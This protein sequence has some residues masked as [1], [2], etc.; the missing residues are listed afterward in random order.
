MSV[1]KNIYSPIRIISGVVFLAW[2]GIHLYLSSS[3]LKVLPL[4]GGFFIFDSILALV[5]AILLFINFKILYLPILVYSWINYLLLTESRVFPAPVLGYSLPQVNAYVIAAL[6][7]DVLAII[8]V[9]VTWIGSR[10]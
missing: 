9:T 4:V 3:L 10:R 8:F 1:I 7:L 6:I 2:A 5:A